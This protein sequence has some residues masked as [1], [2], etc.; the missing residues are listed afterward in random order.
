MKAVLLVLAAAAALLASAAST[1]SAATD[2]LDL[3][4]D[5]VPNPDHVGIYW[6]REHGFFRRASLDVA[7]HAPSDPAAPL[8]LLGVGR[9]DLAISYEPELFLAA[10][11][12]LPVV[13]VAAIVPRPLTSLI[14]RRGSAVRS[15]ADLRGRSL[16]VPGIPAIDAMAAT[17]VRAAGIEA[18]EVHTVR[19]GFNLVPALLAGRVDAIVG[20]YRNV[21]GVQVEQE[22]GRAPVV[23]PVDRAGVPGYDELVVAANAS[24]LR[25][26]PDYA[27]RVR[28]FLAALLA[29]T[30]QARSHPAEATALMGRVTDYRARF[31]R[32]SV[33]LTLRLL[34]RPDRRPGCLDLRGWQRF[35]TWLQESAVLG[36]RVPASRVATNA[37]LP[38]G[39]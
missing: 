37:Y 36:R 34:A 29:G 18:G 3:T 32:A 22:T 4:L 23:V 8:K 1:A 24:R 21:E 12:S 20:G 25:S 11:R 26:D 15:V 39:C 31:L 14:A 35:G 13:A 5:W 16:G 10:Q 38:G 17:I 6:A 2:R 33:P 7:I 30:R 9:T 27:A 28:S 19:V